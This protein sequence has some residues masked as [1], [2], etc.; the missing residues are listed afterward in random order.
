MQMLILGRVAILLIMHIYVCF[1]GGFLFSIIT[2]C[3]NN[4]SFFLNDSRNNTSNLCLCPKF[5]DISWSNNSCSLFTVYMLEEKHLEYILI[6]SN[7]MTRCLKYFC[8]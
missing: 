6:L 2:V 8:K 4:T 3:N 7:N 5:N 1:L